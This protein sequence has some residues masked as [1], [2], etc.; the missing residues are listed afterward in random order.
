MGMLT[1]LKY[2]IQASFVLNGCSIIAFDTREN[3]ANCLIQKRALIRIVP[4]PSVGRNSGKDRAARIGRSGSG[5]VL[6]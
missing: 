2:L 5:A 3:G 4:A 6:W 1:A